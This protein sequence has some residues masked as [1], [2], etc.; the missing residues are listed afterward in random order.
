MTTPSAI[1]GFRDLLGDDL[2]EPARSSRPE[3]WF[4]LCVCGHIDRFHSDSI[5]GSYEVRPPEERVYDGVTEKMVQTFDGCR[6]AMLNRDQ[7]LFTSTVDAATRT[8]TQRLTVTCP[9]ERLRPVADV[10]RP[11][12]F[13]SQKVPANPADRAR[14]PFVV[15]VRAYHKRLA[16]FRAAQADPT[17]ADAEFDRRFTWRAKRHCGLPS[18]RKTDDLL[19]VFVN[20]ELLSELRCPKHRG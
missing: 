2:G 13:F 12:R 6:G 18:C 20:A 15:G 10:D 8:T 4:A 11:G 5:G 14:H 16:K 9:C 7:E 1:Q 17:W 19:P 3:R